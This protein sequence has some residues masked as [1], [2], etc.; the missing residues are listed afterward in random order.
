MT[1][2]SVFVVLQVVAAFVIFVA[3]FLAL[4]AFVML[5]VAL[6]WILCWCAKRLA[7]IVSRSRQERLAS[8]SMEPVGFVAPASFAK[9]SSH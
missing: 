1:S 9:G 4:F 2:P 3:G 8:E 7:V 5:C 6:V